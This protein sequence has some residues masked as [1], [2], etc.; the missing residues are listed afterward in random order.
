MVISNLKRWIAV[1]DWI[2][3]L[4]TENL[5]KCCEC[6]SVYWSPHTKAKYQICIVELAMIPIL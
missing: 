6:S 3:N 4:Q 1:M 2:L 5:D